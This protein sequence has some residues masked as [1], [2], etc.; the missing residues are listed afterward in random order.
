MEHLKAS[1]LSPA[2]VSHLPPS[3]V[4]PTLLIIPSVTATQISEDRFYLDDKVVSGLREW[5]RHWPGPVACIFRAGEAS[6]IAFGREYGRDELP[7]G[8]EIADGPIGDDLL[9]GADIILASGDNHQDFPLAA[10]AK[11]LGIPLCY[12][13]EN[14]L[15]TRLQINGVSS[16]SRWQKLKSGVWAIGSEIQRR[17]AFRDA[18]ALQSNGTPAG[19]AY[20]SINPNVHSYFDTRTARPMMADEAA[21]AA[22]RTRLRLDAKLRLAFS[23]RLE[24]LKGADDLIQVAH[25]LDLIGI[26]FHLDILGA[27]SLEGPM[28]AERHRLG[29]MEKVTFHGGVDFRTQLAPFFVNEVDLFVCCHRQSDPS[30]TYME[31]FAAGVPIVGYSNRAFDGML[32]MGGAG[33]SVRRKSPRAIALK[34][35]ELHRD[36]LIEASAQARSFAE[37]HDMASTFEGRAA[38]LA[39]VL[40][41]YR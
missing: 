5:V 2:E 7:C 6:A 23:G 14:L 29:L 35:N 30:C 15:S 22:R 38:H 11:R 33:W 4:G 37:G 27:G 18:A 13:I 19:N 3:L 9:A 28:R 16:A 20:R 21:M 12:I 40:E 17:R 25:H 10:R 34:I 26:P 31:T 39:S 8:I 24:P 32:A 36:Q 1:S 41:R